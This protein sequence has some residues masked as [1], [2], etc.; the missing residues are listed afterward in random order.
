MALIN[1]EET[2]RWEEDALLS[3]LIVA[4]MESMLINKMEYDAEHPE[5][6]TQID[7]ARMW[8]LA[9]TRVIQDLC[10]PAIE[11]KSRE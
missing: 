8:Q 4:E 1:W 2:I 9:R 3:D 6:V 7:S 11:D 5:H 10:A